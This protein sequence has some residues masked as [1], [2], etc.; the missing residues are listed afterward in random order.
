[1]RACE[2]RARSVIAVYRATAALLASWAASRSARRCTERLS[3]RLQERRQAPMSGGGSG[4]GT[5]AVAE[6]ASL[7]C[8]RRLRIAVCISKLR[9]S[10]PCRPAVR[11]LRGVQGKVTWGACRLFL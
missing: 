11:G 10:M 3:R 9:G 4:S 5:A 6:S 1:M 8:P 2:R 7:P